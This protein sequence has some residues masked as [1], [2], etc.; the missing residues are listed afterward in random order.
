MNY[1]KGLSVFFYK[2]C[3]IRYRDYK[4]S[5]ISLAISW[6][7]G[8]EF[9]SISIAILSILAMSLLQCGHQDLLKGIFLKQTSKC[10]SA[11]GPIQSNDTDSSCL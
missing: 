3:H 10:S 11:A 7:H 1:K 9:S 5:S 8:Y 6:Y 2:S 4:F